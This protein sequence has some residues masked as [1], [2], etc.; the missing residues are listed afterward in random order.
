MLYD[1]VVKKSMIKDVSKKYGRS[2]G[3]ISNQL[4]RYKGSP[5]LLREAI[6]KADQRR[7]KAMAVQRMVHDMLDQGTFI[8][9]ANEVVE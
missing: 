2:Q 4:K 9:S 1:V 3:Y 8:G 6:D 5:N 7:D